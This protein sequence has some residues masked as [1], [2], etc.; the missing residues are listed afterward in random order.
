MTVPMTTR[1]DVAVAVGLV[2]TAPP[3]HRLAAIRFAVAVV[4]GHV[5]G[6]DP[7]EQEQP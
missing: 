4:L 1:E 3:G 2:R 6:P 7:D 5:P